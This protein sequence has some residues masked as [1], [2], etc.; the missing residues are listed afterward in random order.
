MENRGDVRRQE[1]SSNETFERETD[2]LK[3]LWK[4]QWK[5]SNALQQS[6]HSMAM[7]AG[8]ELNGND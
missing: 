4:N 3:G 6:C 7:E 5:Y 1:Q 8:N 2:T